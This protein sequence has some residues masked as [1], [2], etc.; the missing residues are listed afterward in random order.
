MQGSLII[1]AAAAQ[2]RKAV[3]VVGLSTL[4]GQHWLWAGK[5]CGGNKAAATAEAAAMRPLRLV[6]GPGH[7]PDTRTRLL[8]LLPPLPP[9]LSPRPSRR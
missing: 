8:L 4:G 6:C 1:C 5:A 7:N 3:G 2:Y 9:A